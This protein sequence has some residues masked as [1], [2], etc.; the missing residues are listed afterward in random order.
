VLPGKAELDRDVYVVVGGWR[1]GLGL[2]GVGAWWQGRALLRQA[3]CGTTGQSVH[4]RQAA[5]TCW[6]WLAEGAS[7]VA[8]GCAHDIA[9]W[10]QLGKKL[11]IVLAEDGSKF[12]YGEGKTH[13]L[14]FN[15][16]Q[17]E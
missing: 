3:W 12:R 4:G 11:G 13:I 16:G 6:V 14:L 1:G 10:A 5:E 15:Y 7:G 17:E 8:M 2:H 9:S